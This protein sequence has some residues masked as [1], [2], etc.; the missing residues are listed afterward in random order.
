MITPRSGSDEPATAQSGEA[1]VRLLPAVLVPGLARSALR[2]GNRQEQSRKAAPLRRRRFARPLRSATG[3]TRR[4]HAKGSTANGRGRHDCRLAAAACRWRPVPDRWLRARRG[5]ARA[6]R[7]PRGRRYRWVSASAAASA[8][9]GASTTPARR[10]RR[11]TDPPAGDADK[12]RSGRQYGSSHQ[13]PARLVN[14]A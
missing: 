13:A 7:A 1:R 3:R 9:R 4:S 6:R 14:F 2:D 10:A 8:R 11:P 12:P 5:T